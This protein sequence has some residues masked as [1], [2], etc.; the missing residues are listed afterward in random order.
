[1]ENPATGQKATAVKHE[2][3]IPHT[4]KTTVI[5]PSYIYRKKKAGQQPSRVIVPNERVKTGQHGPNSRDPF[6]EVH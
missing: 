3:Y 2:R 6:R 4:H 5:Y 1:M